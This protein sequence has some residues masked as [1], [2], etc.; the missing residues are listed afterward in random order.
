MISPLK[1]AC[2]AY[3]STPKKI[4]F[5]FVFCYLTFYLLPSP[6]L[7]GLLGFVPGS[8]SITARVAQAWMRVLPWFATHLFHLSGPAVMVYKPSGT[9]DK[10]L[11]YV[12]HLAFVLLAAIA[13]LIWSVADSRRPNYTALD[14]WLRL[15]IRYILVYWMLG[16]GLNKVIPLQFVPPNLSAL[17]TPI[18]Q[19]SLRNLYWTLTGASPG[20]VIFMG[21]AELLAGA[22]LLFKRTSV[23]GALVTTGV[24]SNVVAV[25]LGYDVGVKLFSSHLLIMA[26]FLLAPHLR[27]LA[28]FFVFQKPAGLRDMDPFESKPRWIRLGAMIAKIVL[29]SVYVVTTTAT[30]WKN[31]RRWQSFAWDTPVY[32]IYGVDGFVRNGV[33]VPPLATDA[34]RWRKL[35][36][37]TPTGVVVE[38]MNERSAFYPARYDSGNHILVL[39]D[40]SR[41]SEVG[42]FSYLQ[43]DQQHLVLDGVLANHPLSIRLSRMDLSML[44]LIHNRFAWIHD[45]N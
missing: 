39:L 4:L 29:I 22:L 10:T 3:W 31:Y 12:M 34:S 24:L 20:Y 14:S 5:R 13:A 44:P 42:R 9:G 35:V 30:D 40:P 11:D 45:V 37:Q 32:G 17:L 25:N 43:P 23:L 15:G 28:D 7:E 21:A 26:I 19:L 2:E 33:D 27:T 38:L 6:Q 36:L 16:F 41:K 18:G 8:S 1:G